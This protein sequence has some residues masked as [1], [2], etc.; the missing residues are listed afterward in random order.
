[1]IRD[2]F[3]CTRKVE[4]VFSTKWHL[5]GLPSCEIGFSICR[6]CGSVCQSP[7]VT[8]NQM[9]TFYKTLAVYTNPGRAGQPSASKVTDL[10]EQLRFIERGMGRL[11]NSV[12]QIGSSDGYSLSRFKA[13]GVDRVLGVE[14]SKS[15]ADL[16]QL[17][18]NI[19]TITNSA[20][21]FKTDENF[22]LILLT[23]VLEHLFEPQKTLDKC[24][25]QQA[26]IDEGFIY[27][28][29]P[30]LAT[31]ESLCPGFFA[32]EHVNYYTRQNLIQSLELTGYSVV[33]LVEHYNSNLS[34]VIG[35]LASTKKQKYVDTPLNEFER[36]KEILEHYR[37]RELKSWQ[38]KLNK[39]LLDLQNQK[40]LFLWGAGIH[41]SQ[42]LANTNL[43]KVCKISGLIDGSN[44]KWGIKQGDWIVKDPNC[45]DWKRGD[46][47][48]ISSYASEEEI[49]ES[50]A[51]LRDVGVKT[52][53][54]HNY[55][56]SRSH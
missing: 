44:L 11:P 29:V 28:E 53:R 19:E 3:F 27:I 34:P 26:Q 9:L 4:V 1:M 15:S 50:L 36:N 40:R 18:Y 6:N 22:E 8:H 47:I 5:P 10:N 54:L 17:L 46:A 12:L 41:T 32:F 42:L 35:V 55:N 38:Q 31:V 43:L 25:K 37:I 56:N 16:A 33:S 52:Y 48:L 39:I 30:L 20:E 23:H 13:A 49:H 21:D 24:L 2:C 45:I 7:T 14:P 51:Y